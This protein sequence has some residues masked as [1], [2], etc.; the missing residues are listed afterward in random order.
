MLAL[1]TLGRPTSNFA[2]EKG[3]PISEDV[4]VGCILKM[5][6]SRKKEGE[7]IFTI[8]RDK[9]KTKMNYFMGKM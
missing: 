5:F 2:P 6:P 1:T 3:P 9:G 7:I 8:A 4:L